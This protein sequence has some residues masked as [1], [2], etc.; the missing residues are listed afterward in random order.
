MEIPKL[1]PS[2][3]ITLIKKELMSGDMKVND[4]TLVDL[5]RGRDISEVVNLMM[6]SGSIYNRRILKFFRWFCKWMPIAIML[7]H[8]YGIYDFAQ[9]NRPTFILARATIFA[10]VWAYFMLY[11]LPLVI[12]LASRFFFLCWRY[13]IPFYYFIGVN[14]IHL[15]YLSPFTTADM[16]MTH[17]CLMIFICIAYI[18]GFLEMFFKS[19]MG[20]KI[21]L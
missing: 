1:T 5:L 16:I 10:D 12:I 11:I 20:K 14:A 17:Y 3:A 19:D 8:W 4:K 13:R 9:D 2:E 6:H 18:V 21:F 15:A 7:A